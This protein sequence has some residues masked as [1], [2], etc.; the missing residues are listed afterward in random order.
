MGR[1]GGLQDWLNDRLG[2]LAAEHAV[3]G[4]VVAVM[5]GDEVAETATG[6]LSLAAGSR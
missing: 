4:A 5:A 1:L 6:V 3:P 2:A